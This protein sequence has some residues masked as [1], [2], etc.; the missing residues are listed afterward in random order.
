MKTFSLVALTLTLLHTSCSNESPSGNLD[1]YAALCQEL[2]AME[3]LSTQLG[4][5]EAAL[6][7]RA[8]AD[9]LRQAVQR[10]CWDERDGMY[11]SVDIA[12]LPA[13]PREQMFFG[14]PFLLHEGAPRKYPCLIQRIGSWTGFMTLWA[15]IATPDQAERMVK[16][17]LTDERTFWAPYGVRTLSKMEAMYSMEATHNP[18]NWNGPIWGVSNYMVWR[19]LKQYGFDHEARQLAERTIRLFGQ[20]LEQCGE[21]HEYYN[22]D[23]GEGIINPG[24]Q[25][26]NYLVLDMIK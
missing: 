3:Y 2:L 20:D 11:Y 18:S 15:G 23:T 26:W 14:H 5:T 8:E 9:C 24:F 16:E 6:R 12:L 21:L 7:H 19:G 22:P 25:N 13:E 1:R 4:H 10:Y 17:N